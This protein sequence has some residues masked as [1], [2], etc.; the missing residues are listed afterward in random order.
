MPASMLVS[1]FLMVLCVLPMYVQQLPIAAVACF[2]VH[3][4]ARYNT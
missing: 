1:A 2:L 4:T 3:V